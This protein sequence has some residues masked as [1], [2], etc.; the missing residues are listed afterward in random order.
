MRSLINVVGK[1]ILVIFFLWHMFSVAVYSIPRDAKDAFSQWSRFDL[2]PLVTPY[3]YITSQW[4]LWNI[5]AP[6]PLRRVTTYRTEIRRDNGWVQLE[7]VGPDSFSIFRHAT[8]I[9][10][11]GNML[12][13]FSDNR[14]A[15]AG[16]Y[17][18]LLCSEHNVP[19]GTP[20]RLWYDVYILPFLT[21][22]Q[23]AR[24]WRE[25]QPEYSSTLGFSTTCP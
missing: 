4:Q 16:R 18:H 3:M 23:T 14:A 13:E 2:L 11:M 10:L 21:E 5:F 12:D 22:P 25:W 7:A 17:L 1:S 19:S 8:R 20:M 9:K 6:D 24:W 15:I